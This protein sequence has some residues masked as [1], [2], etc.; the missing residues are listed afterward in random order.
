M[1]ESLN[2]ELKIYVREQA[3][4]A[5]SQFHCEVSVMSNADPESYV[6]QSVT[7]HSYSI[8]VQMDEG[9]FKVKKILKK[10]D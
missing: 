2:K 7:G 4:K 6:E 9:L 1:M 8:S 10:N 5:T 3:N